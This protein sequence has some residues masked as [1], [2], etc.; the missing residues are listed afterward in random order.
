ML[1]DVIRADSAGR[2]VLGDLTR[3]EANQVKVTSHG[4]AVL[5]ALAGISGEGSQR[6]LPRVHLY[7][8]DPF[9]VSVDAD[10]ET[11]LLSP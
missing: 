11:P 8:P 10:D 9:V 6:L 5:V 3:Q 1:L 7:H 4:R 2:Q